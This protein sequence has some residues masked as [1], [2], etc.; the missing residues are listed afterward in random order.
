MSDTKQVELEPGFLQAFRLFVVT[1]IVF[2]VVIGP[3]LIIVQMARSSN[4]TPDEITAMTS[5]ER[6]TLPSVAPV[7]AVELLLL[8]LLLLPQ[9]LRRLGQSFVPVT[10]L[11]GL[12]PVLI[13]FYWWPSENP[14]QSPFTIFLFVMLVL[15]AWQYPFRH[16]LAYVLGLTLYQA[17]VTSPMTDMPFSVDAGWLMLQGAMMLLVGYVIVQLVSLQREQRVAL[18][19]AYEQQAAA[20]RR[21]QRYADTLEELAVSRERNRLARELH[22]TLAHSLSAV[23]VQLEAVRS[24][25][26]LNSEAA[27]DLLDKADETA[28]S[29]LTEARRALQAL[30]ASPLLDLG[31]AL[32]LRELAQQTTQRA[33]ARLELGIPEKIAADLSPAVE[34]EIYRIAQETLENIVRHADA[35]SVLLKL[36]QNP[37]SL[38]L[39]IEDNGRGMEAHASQV[40][41][42]SEQRRVGIRGMKERASVAI[43]RSALRQGEAPGFTLQSRYRLPQHPGSQANHGLAQPLMCRRMADDSRAHL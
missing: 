14:L 20:N 2:W 25:W 16:V 19:R 24:L 29:G 18:G 13:G 22:D 27:K 1:R 30:R 5:V 10:L 37:G 9:A 32:A 4:V 39:T 41:E 28:R 40:S 7:I 35:T 42:S 26:Y 17:W 3:I 36:E 12:V 38:A 31:L 8:A 6:L 23:T 11:I 43:W 33:G 21:L 15:I 34:Q